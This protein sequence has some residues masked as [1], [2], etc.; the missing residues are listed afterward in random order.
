MKWLSRFGN[1]IA[2]FFIR[3]FIGSC[4]K[5]SRKGGD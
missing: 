5:A 4:E 2:D 3:L 1:A